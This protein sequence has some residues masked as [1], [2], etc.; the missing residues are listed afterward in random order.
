MKIIFKFIFLFFLFN[1]CAPATERPDT[2][3]KVQDD[4]N[5]W[6][7]KNL[8]ELYLMSDTNLILTFTNINHT[9]DSLTEHFRQ[10]EY[11]FDK[12]K[13]SDL[14]YVKGEIYFKMGQFL[15]ALIEFSYD[16]SAIFGVARAAAYIKLDKGDK[17]NEEIKNFVNGPYEYQWALGNYYE[18]VGKIDSAKILYSNIYA[19]DSVEYSKCLVRIN[20]LNKMHPILLKEPYLPTLRS[21]EL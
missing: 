8:P 3:K 17:A 11:S 7:N 1:S 13:F 12:N 6:Q 5:D 2:D 19:A 10:T 20:E 21:K 16:S 9:I 4:I 18:I 15:N 14:H